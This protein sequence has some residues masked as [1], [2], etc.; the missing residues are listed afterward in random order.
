MFSDKETQFNL[1]IN[2]VFQYFNKI[3]NWEN[4]KFANFVFVLMV[5]NGSNSRIQGQFN[6]VDFYSL[7]QQIKDIQAQ[8]DSIPINMREKSFN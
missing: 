8:S 3:N 6:F 2:G 5:F 7:L 1:L 4:F